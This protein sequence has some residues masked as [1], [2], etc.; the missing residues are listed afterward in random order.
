[1]VAMVLVFCGEDGYQDKKCEGEY[2]SVYTFSNN[3][4]DELYLLCVCTTITAAGL[5]A[6][7]SVHMS[8]F[9]MTTAT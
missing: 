8:S 6:Y 9:T 3:T 7:T 2:E 1:M 5:C 4:A